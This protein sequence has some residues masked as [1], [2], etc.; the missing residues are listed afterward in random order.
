MMDYSSVSEMIS[1]YWGT[2]AISISS[3]TIV[4]MAVFLFGRWVSS[5]EKK[6]RLGEMLGVEIEDIVGVMNPNRLERHSYDF[7]DLYEI[8]PRK[9]YDGL[10]NSS[11]IS[12]FDLDLQKKL[13]HFYEYDRVEKYEKMLDN[14]EDVSARI[15]SFRLRNA[16]PWNK[17]KIR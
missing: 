1:L 9:I 8:I 16:W 17:N 11:N 2:A 4:A 12:E 3:A 7:R 6:F 14:I 10:V 15:K 13:H 5:K